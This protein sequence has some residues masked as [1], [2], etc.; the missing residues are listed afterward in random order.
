MPELTAELASPDAALHIGPQHV[1]L[2][3]AAIDYAAALAGTERL[4]MRSWHVMFL[5]RAKTGPFRVDGEAR[6]STDQAWQ[7]I[8]LCLRGYH[9]AGGGEAPA[10]R[11][12]RAGQWLPVS[13]RACAAP[14]TRS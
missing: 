1:L 9:R 14:T 6:L 13:A 3:T 11:S 8:D 4:Q 5:A 2:E 7:P 12:G 10:K